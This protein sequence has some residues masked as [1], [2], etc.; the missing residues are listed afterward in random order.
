LSLPKEQAVLKL[1]A[2]AFERA[3]SLEAYGFKPA[4]ALH[5]AAAEQ[6]GA[7][8]LLTCDDRLCRTARRR[9]RQLRVRV[10]NPLDWLQEI[11]HGPN[12]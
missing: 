9:R 12:P 3:A 7:D 1:G 8:V 2:E 10:A 6:Q 11:G 4:D 5:V